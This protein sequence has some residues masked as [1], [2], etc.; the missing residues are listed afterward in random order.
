M[1]EFALSYVSGLGHFLR[2]GRKH[3]ELKTAYFTDSPERDFFGEKRRKK[4]S[5]DMGLG[6]KYAEL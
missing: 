3:T 6:V 5:A 4:P 1:S 2:L